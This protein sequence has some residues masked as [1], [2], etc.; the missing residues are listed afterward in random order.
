MITIFIIIFPQILSSKQY[1]G[2][3]KMVGH[4]N[5][6]KHPILIALSWASLWCTWNKQV[7]WT[8]GKRFNLFSSAQS[9]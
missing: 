5:L 7:Q 2:L 9:L 1:S 8:W 3:T 6:K 4:Q